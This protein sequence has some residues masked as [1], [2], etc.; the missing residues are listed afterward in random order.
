M[1]VFDIY[2]CSEVEEHLD[3]G[4]VSPIDGVVQKC[5]FLRPRIYNVG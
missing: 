5:I 2:R 3:H 1:F 4:F